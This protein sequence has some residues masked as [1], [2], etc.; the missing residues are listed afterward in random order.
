RSCRPGG[1][2]VPRKSR[3]SSPSSP[4]TP[5]ATSPARSSASTAACTEMAEP[6]LRPS[7]H[8]AWIV[9]PAYCEAR[10]IRQLTLDALAHCPRVIVVDDGSSDGT[11]AAL[12]G[13][14][15]VV[16]RHESNRGKAASLRTA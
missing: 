3:R 16:L 10:T 14:P 11:S 6:V 4:P 2:G 8:G 9:I 13:L 7:W 15:V 12:Q 1:P 5:P